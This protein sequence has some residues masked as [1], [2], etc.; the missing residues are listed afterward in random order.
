MKI[1]IKEQ[2]LVAGVSAKIMRADGIAIVFGKTIYLWNT[3]RKDFLENK[4]WL[5][6]ELVHVEQF[7]RYG[8]G[9]FIF[10][11]LYETAKNGYSKNKFEVEARSRENDTT[12]QADL[13]F[14]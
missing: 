14:S 12:L 10:L 11:Y 3:R 6:H 4:Q 1:I 8:F 7:K 5:R 13:F 2:S 9:K